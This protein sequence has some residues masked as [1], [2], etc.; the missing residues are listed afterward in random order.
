MFIDTDSWK[1]PPR[2]A[3]AGWCVD[4]RE[5]DAPAEAYCALPGG[6]VRQ[7]PVASEEEGCRMACVL[8]YYARP[9]VSVS[10][11]NDPACAECGTYHV[12]GMV[13]HS[14]E[15]SRASTVSPSLT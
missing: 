3:V 8:S 5:R 13:P 2:K 6:N 15:C 1:N 11:Y 4:V 14:P 10:W 12:G 7:I 9:G